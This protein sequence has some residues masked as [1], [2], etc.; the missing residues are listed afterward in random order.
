MRRLAVLS[1]CSF[2]FVQAALGAEDTWSLLEADWLRQAD[3]WIAPPKPPQT[4]EDARGAVDGVKD[5]TYA[6]HLGHQPNPWSP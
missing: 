3:A 2:V 6:F 4:F 5:G 1:L